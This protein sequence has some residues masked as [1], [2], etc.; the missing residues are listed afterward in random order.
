MDHQEMDMFLPDPVPADLHSGHIP[1]LGRAGGK[2]LGQFRPARQSAVR[3]L[4]LTAVPAGILFRE[5]RKRGVLVRYFEKPRIDNYLRIT[6]GTD[7][8]MDILIS[9][10]RTILEEAL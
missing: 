2:T 6:I 1:F 4:R 8:E 5:L 10:L 7:E 3:S 9:T